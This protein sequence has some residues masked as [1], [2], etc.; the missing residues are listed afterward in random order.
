MRFHRGL[1]CLP[2]GKL[3]DGEDP[4]SGALRE[5]NVSAFNLLEPTVELE[6]STRLILSIGL[7]IWC[8]S[9][10]IFR[11]KVNQLFADV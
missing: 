6:S 8:V 10:K 4:V 1:V 7:K 9:T 5:A 3:E 11:R 2:G